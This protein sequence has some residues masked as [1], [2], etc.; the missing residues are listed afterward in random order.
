MISP[1]SETLCVLAFF[2]LGLRLKNDG[3]TPKER[4]NGRPVRKPMSTFWIGHL[5]LLEKQ[6]LHQQLSVTDAALSLH[7]SSRNVRSTV[8]TSVSSGSSNRRGCPRSFPVQRLP[9]NIQAA[10]R[11]GCSSKGR[12]FRPLI[13]FWRFRDVD[14][15]ED[16][17]E[18]GKRT[19]S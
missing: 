2:A 10:H 15:A 8:P 4:G 16:C 17:R 7:Q 13:L 14:F 5:Q 11:V 1:Y 19:R 12:I 6:Y 18:P 9:Q 3:P